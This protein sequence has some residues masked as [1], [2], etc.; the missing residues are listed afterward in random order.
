MTDKAAGTA[1][2]STTVGDALEAILAVVRPLPAEDVCLEEAAG[3]VLAVPVVAAEDLWPFPR[4][5]MD[6]VAVRA[7]D[8]AQARASVPATLRVVGSVYSGQVWPGPLRPGEA[9]RIATGA[10]VPEGADAVIPQELLEWTADQVVVRQPVPRGRHVFPAGEDAR[11]GETV[12]D[13]GHLLRG[14]DLSLLAALGCSRV[15]V[16]RQPAVAVLAAGDE[17]VPPSAGLRPGQVRESNSYGLAA[18]IAAVGGLPR[19]IQAARDDGSDLEA[20]IREGLGADA[21]VITGGVSVGERDLVRAALERAGAVFGF[22][23]VSMK[24]GA[25]VAFATAGRTLVF[26]LPGT[27][28]AARIAFEMLV[29]PALSTL[30]GR[31]QTRRP[32]VQAVL[33]SPLQVVPGRHRFLWARVTLGSSGIHVIPLQGQGTATLRSAS[34]ANALMELLP[35]EGPLVAGDEV[36]VHLLDDLSSTEPVPIMPRSRAAVCVVGARDSGKTTLIERLIPALRSRGLSVAAVK[37]HVHLDEP[38]RAGT[39][40]ARFASAGATQTVLAGPGGIIKRRAEACDP[41]LTEVLAAAGPADLVLVE[42]YSQSHLPKILVRRAGVAAD[43][44]DPA[45]PIVAIVTDH[46]DGR[47]DL[48]VFGWDQIDRL[49]VLIAGLT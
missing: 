47:G 46:D 41:P 33:D 23:G 43:R 42:G 19:R 22:V 12:L 5:A 49:A 2:R 21:L 35:E 7:G 30:A 28:G 24:P 39:D 11:A 25:P 34:Q 16:F 37:H 36:R 9:L 3:R 40:T 15:T 4:A 1:P 44:P 20:R 32:V 45:G 31:R 17:L 8:V 18:E 27:P 13:A 6:G 29:R 14:G 10:P 38:E 26:A 48:P